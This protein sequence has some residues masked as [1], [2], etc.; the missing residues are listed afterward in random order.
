MQYLIIAH[1][2]FPSLVLVTSCG[3]HYVYETDMW[4]FFV[5]LFLFVVG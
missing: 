4:T 5:C 1:R 3:Y 2:F